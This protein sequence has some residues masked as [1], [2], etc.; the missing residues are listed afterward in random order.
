MAREPFRPFRATD[1]GQWEVGKVIK[2]NAL[3]HHLHRWQIGERRE[4]CKEGVR[5]R[6]PR[7]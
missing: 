6:L 1:N 2:R 3:L 7:W 4:G 5:E